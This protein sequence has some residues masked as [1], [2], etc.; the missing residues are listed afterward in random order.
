MNSYSLLNWTQD[1]RNM[2]LSILK[3]YYNFLNLN[4]KQKSPCVSAS[5]AQSVF[6]RIPSAFICVHLRLIFVSLND[7]IQEIHFELFQ[8][9]N[10]NGFMPVQRRIL[11]RGK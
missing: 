2:G 10:E 11:R 6:H 5:S 8:K 4:V 1:I 7:R 3:K 9:I